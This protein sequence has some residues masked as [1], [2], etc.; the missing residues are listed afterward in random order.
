MSVQVRH[1]IAGDIPDDLYRFGDR[2]TSMDSL[3][4]I[5]GGSFARTLIIDGQVTGA[6]GCCI[7]YPGVA[8]AW[9]VISDKARGHGLPM[10]RSV[11]RQMSQWIAEL[12]LWRVSA[13]VMD[14]PR[15]QE[16]M[17]WIELLGFTFE[18]IEFHAGP[19]A[20]NLWRY[21]WIAADQ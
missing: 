14:G 16:Y 9:A 5:H 1:Y 10:T 11:Q 8:D 13:Y 17:R 12:G 18:G 21:R 15:R 19:H 20:E 7:R 3:L 4:A 2:L 6:F